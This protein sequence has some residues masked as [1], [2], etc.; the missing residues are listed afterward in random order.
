M[1]PILNPL[2]KYI[3]QVEVEM[4]PGNSNNEFFFGL[5]KDQGKDNSYAYG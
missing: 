2:Q 4:K 3:L 5:V 1:D